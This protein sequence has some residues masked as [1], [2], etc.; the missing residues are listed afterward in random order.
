[1]VSTFVD[2]L[3]SMADD[4]GE[5]H[6]RLAGYATRI[7][8]AENIS[9]LSGLVV[10]VMQD[11]RAV[12]ADL[13]RS[14]TELL[15][16]RRRVD[17]YQQQVQKL[18]GEMAVLSDRLHEDQLTQLL[19]RRGLAR[20]FEAE[21][22]RADRYQRPL[23]LAVLDVDDFKHLNDRLGHQAGD[24]ALVHLARIVRR[25][26]R[27]T[28]VISRYGGEEF[29]ILL[30]E[31]LLDEAV[32]VMARVQRELTRRIFLHNH[33]RVLI[34]FSAGVAQRV[35]GEQQDELIARADR[36]LYHAKQAGKNRV[37]AAE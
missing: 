30:P 22:S 15:E 3:S 4:T 12:Q 8:R 7:E 14:R 6:D 21:I 25:S 34:T 35:S 16:S 28:D 10:E 20:A 27:P 24:L 23:C 37:A 33:E 11:T 36:A 1:M 13:S 29:V 31:T 19:N 18:E 9:E 17:E 5:Y 32:R 2:R 26:I